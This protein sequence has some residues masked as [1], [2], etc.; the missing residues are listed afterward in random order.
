MTFAFLRQQNK[1]GEKMLRIHR[2]AGWTVVALVVIIAAVVIFI[3]T[4]DW[5]RA[6]PWI[7]DKVTQ[8]I[9]RPF[10]INGDLRVS[11]TR[12]RDEHG[13]RALVPWP[14]FSAEKITVGNPSWARRPNFASLDRIDFE[15]EVL[16]LLVHKIVIPTIRLSNPAV[17]I[18]R[19]AQS[20]N[21]WTFD[22]K[23]SDQPS[24]WTLDLHDIAFAKGQVTATDAIKK[25]DFTVGIDTLGQ[26]IPMA[27]M[28]R[29]QQAASHA[30]AAE[31]VGA[32]GAKALAAQAASAASGASAATVAAGSDADMAHTHAGPGAA[33]DAQPG[34]GGTTPAYSIGLRVQGVFN[35]TKISGDGRIGGVLALQDAARPFPVQADVRIGDTRIAV[36]GTLTDPA[37]LAALD[38]QL[39][40]SGVSLAHLYPVTGV[41]LPDTPPY[42]TQGHLIGQFDKNGDVFRYENF[43]GRVG[44]SDLGGNIVYTGR[45]PRPLVSA[46]LVS[47]MLRFA[48][49]AP[50]IGADSN[51]SKAKRGAA[52]NQPSDRALP[53]EE[54][55]TDRWKAIDAD[56]KFT[57][58]HIVRDP[59]LPI[60]NLYTHLVMNGGVLTLEPLRFGVASGTLNA[61]VRLDGSTTPLRGKMSV[62]ARHLKLKEL[63]P[64]FDPM[65]TALGEVNGNAALSA[66]GNSPAALAATSNGEVKVLV[67]EGVISKFLTEAAGLNVANAVVTRLFGDKS[68][69]INCAASDFVMTDGVLDTKV[70]A[71]DTEDT[72][73]TV[74]GNINL[75][76][77]QMD[78]DIRPHTKGLRVFSLR[79]PLYVKGTFKQP[80]VGVNAEVLALR[81]GAAVGLGL[82]NPIAA[83]IPLVIP[84]MTRD[85]SPCAAMVEQLKSAP[86]APEPGKKMPA[87]TGASAAAA[88]RAASSALVTGK[89]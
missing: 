75:R 52:P 82:I 48:D 71:F 15:V 17:D 18:E 64:K 36:V 40:L 33:S 84:N 37:H 44:G 77:E 9:G 21:N 34:R 87:A 76:N 5:N 61:D 73:V 1:R 13:V 79:A 55:R 38:I 80:H 6:R 20:R 23:K 47:N 54:F 28:M 19:D 14:H 2:I 22:T 67:S 83:L 10:A 12:A 16:P 3:L 27:E 86:V 43:T 69:K 74:G 81:G 31:Q 63:F 46:T 66:T 78:L 65:R 7:D 62:E 72:L 50:V 68:V 25:A 41:T 70:L 30:G 4:F 42:A 60:D 32:R 57:G 49:L 8:A 45:R 35:A 53:T 88:A 26:P 59:Q 51:I 85:K 89:P 56:V 24:K 29:R 39:W 58:K 11:L